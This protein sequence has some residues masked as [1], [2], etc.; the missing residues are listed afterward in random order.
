MADLDRSTG[1]AGD[2]SVTD[3]WEM[4]SREP[5]AQLVDVRTAAE[6]TYVGLPDLPGAGRKTH[7]VEWQKFPGGVPNPA[8]TA[9]AAAALGPDKDIP[10]LF[11]CRSGVRSRA[12]AIAMTEAGYTKA[13]NIAGGFEG[14]LDRERHRSK[15]NGWKASGLPWGQT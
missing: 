6:W 12:A 3:A 1:Y 8:F 10:A 15:T 14:D 5:R 2:I 9:E 7:C 4:L 13:F 11:L